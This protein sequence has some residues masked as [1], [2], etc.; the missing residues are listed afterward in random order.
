MQFSAR[1]AAESC[2]GRLVGDDVA[3]DGAS[4]DSRT[5]RPGELFVPIVAERD[6][7]DFIPAALA[8][9]APAYLTTGRTAGTAPAIVVPDTA[10]ALT[11]LG[12]WARDRLTAGVGPRA[13]GITGSVGKTSVKD[14]A[15]AAV[16]ARWR[17][18][19]NPRSFNNE[20]GLPITLLGAPDD[21]EALILEMG[22]RG[23]GEIRQLCNVARPS[24]GVVTLVAPAHTERV[25]GIDGV[26]R[27]KAELVEALPADGIAILNAGDSRVMAM[28]DR[29][30]ARV[31]TFGSSESGADVAVADLRLDERARASFTVRTPWGDAAVTLVVPGAHMAT[32]AAAA[33]AVALACDV[34]LDAAAARLADAAL[35]PWRMEIAHSR[36][37]VIVL[38]DAYNANPTSMRAALF[39][40]AALTSGRRVAVLG[41]MAELDDPEPAH[42]AIADEAEA[43]GIELV[44]VGTDLY[45]VAP[46]ED[47]L[48]VLRGLA[49]GDAVLVKGSRVAGLEVIAARLL[50]H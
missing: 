39:A 47:P 34:P 37:G 20:Q 48:A 43:M 42:R 50:E 44:I 2:G 46:V 11:A 45:G 40:L 6:G 26:A 10:D 9:G 8:A 32:N 18:A 23:P 7:H 4:F 31:L 41:V 25:G 14:L 38:N 29:T 1:S 33:L 49:E 35:S 30:E 36:A 21:S 28:A 15:A 3:L 27:A 22:M 17:V 24:I 13:V 5:L 16:A 12:R 19:A